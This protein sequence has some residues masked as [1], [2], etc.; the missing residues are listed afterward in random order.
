M[1]SNIVNQ[2]RIIKLWNRASFR[3]LVDGAANNWFRLA[4]DRK[5]EIIDPTPNLITG[6]FDSICPKVRKYYETEVP[7]CKVLFTPDQD[8]TD[9]TKSLY[10]T[11]KEIQKFESIERV[12][13]FTEY[14]GRLDQIF[15]LFET[16]FQAKNIQGLPPVHLVSSNSTDWLL[17]PGFHTINVQDNEAGNV[18]SIQGK[19]LED[20]YC[21][22][23]P[24]GQPCTK[25]KTSGLKWNLATDQTLAF[26]TMVSTSNGFSSNVV[27]V[28][29]DTHLIW[30]ME[31]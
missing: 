17:Q 29:T 30:T 15:G 6:D 24:L 14:S 12:F 8:L 7:T 13:A 9:F 19:K 25:I 1:N 31:N 5:Q 27:T 10:E 18:S 28:E 20:Y 21:G 16:L 2:D 26:G 3:V 22:L 11:S 4:Q 23:I